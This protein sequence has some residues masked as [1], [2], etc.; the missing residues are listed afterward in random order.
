MTL[1]RGLVVPALALLA[2]ELAMRL[3][4]L[5]SDSVAA[6]SAIAAAFARALADGTLLAATGET[7]GAAAAGL[8]LGGGAGLLLAV[9][10]GLSPVLARLLRVP[11]DAFRP[12]PSV[13]LIPIALL[14][15]GFGFRMEIAIVGFAC[16]WPM[17]IVGQAA[18]AG[19][20]PRLLEVARVLRLSL[21]A[22]TVKI[23]L[24]AALPRLFVAFRLAAAV[25]LIVAVTVEITTN[26]L[27]LGYGLMLAQQSL[28]PDLMFAFLLWLGILGWGVNALLLLA[29]RRLFGRAGLV[30]EEA[31]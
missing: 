13:A 16:F 12:I 25:S 15:Y 2:A 14:A 29:Q 26:P 11:V 18:I 23:V 24:P 10:L 1:P 9:A 20:E 21:L 8:A 7:L 22:R 6:P 19:I 4:G 5:Q 3:S 17:L 28:E 30:G 31:R 27:G